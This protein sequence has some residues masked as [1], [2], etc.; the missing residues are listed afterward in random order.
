[1]TWIPYAQNGEDVR[2]RRAFKNQT[3][4]FYI[5][6]GANHP[7]NLSITKHFYDNGWTGINIEPAPEPFTL[8]EKDRK[9]DINI[10]VGCSNYHGKSILHTS[11]GEHSVFSSFNDEHCSIAKK[12]GC[13]FDDIIVNVTTLVDICTRYV[14]NRQIEFISIDVEGHER[15]VLEG[16]NFNHF[17]PRV[18]LVE[19][20]LPNQIPTHEQWE[21]LILSHGYTFAVFDGLNRWYIRREDEHL[22]PI[23]ALSP[24]VFDDYIPHGSSTGA[25]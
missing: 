18:L 16:A 12:K 9:R 5:D 20:V 1:M 2:L 4:G 11:S 15:Q 8:I 25:L 6:I 24:N 17:R 10:N 3:T 21:H 14:N 7:V 22:V 23:I 13:T 19:A